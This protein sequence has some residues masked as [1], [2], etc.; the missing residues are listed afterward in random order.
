M[1]KKILPVWA[2]FLCLGSMYAQSDVE[3]GLNAINKDVLRGQLDYLASDWMEGRG[4]AERGAYMAADYIA[5]M[6]RVYG[7]QPGGD[8]EWIYPSRD[9]R[10]N[11]KEAYQEKTFFQNLALVEYTEGEAQQFSIIE[12]SK[13]GERIFHLGYHTDFS[14]NVSS[15]GLECSAPVVFVGYGYSD[16]QQGYD[17]FKGVDVTGKVILRLT[18]VPGHK[19]ETSPA[20]SKYV[21]QERYG[22]WAIRNKKDDMAKEKGAL[23]IIEVSPDEDDVL[24]WA[25]NVPFHYQRDQ[26]EGPKP[27]EPYLRLRAPGDEFS[28]RLT[29][30]SVSRRAVSKLLEGSA[31]DLK[32]YEQKAAQLVSQKAVLL[33]RSVHLKTSVQSRIV[34]AR[35]VVGVIE[36]KNTNEYIVVGAHYDHLGV[37]NGYTYNGADDNGSGTVGIMSIAKA[38]M[39]TGVKPD[40][41]IIFAAWTGEEK[42]LIGSRYYTNTP[43][44]P[45]EQIKYYANFD[46][47]S[48]NVKDTAGVKCAYTYTKAFESLKTISEEHIEQYDLGLELNYRAQEKPRGGSDHMS[49]ANKDIPVT[50]MIT[51]LHE[52]YHTPDDELDRVC[53]DKMYK[54]VKLGFLNIWRLANDPDLLKSEL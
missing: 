42:G 28:D 6:F 12:N 11:G 38:I 20:Y 43:T 26:Y 50:C 36:G 52:D 9:E 8:E 32:A 15:H 19:D 22:M 53:Y 18:G 4:T 45:I 48:R 21:P 39:A 54:V 33:N 7:L 51:G 41:S 40:K 16:A 23:A 2:F 35:N 37:K 25:D 44:V 3:K 47:I 34:K 14:V 49:F 24:Y 5:S 13:H 31:I 10:M 46:M 27:T 1:I 17:D 30:I 29:A